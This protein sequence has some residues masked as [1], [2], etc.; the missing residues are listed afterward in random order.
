[1][2]IIE[3]LKPS[4]S[5]D[6]CEAYAIWSK[7]YFGTSLEDFRKATENID[8]TVLLAKNEKSIVGLSVLVF[9]ERRQMWSRGELLC[10]V[11]CV[12]ITD[13]SNYNEIANKFYDTAKQLSNNKRCIKLS[14]T[15]FKD[16][17]FF[18]AIGLDYDRCVCE[19]HLT[20]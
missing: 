18:T 19:Y 13:E 20:H 16:R 3:T 11:E 9:Y 17:R 4:N 2:I 14:V 15:D 12:R 1:M 5:D 8:I 6:L 10:D 7:G